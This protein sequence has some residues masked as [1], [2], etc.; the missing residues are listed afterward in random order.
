MQGPNRM[1]AMGKST[2][3]HGGRTFLR[4]FKLV[5]KGNE[6]RLALVFLCIIVSALV[7]VFVSSVIR[8][9]IDDYITP[10][11]LG[12]LTGFSTLG[13]AML[14]WAAVMLMGVISVFGYTRIMVT[15]AQ[16]ALRDIRNRM[17]EKLERLPIS[18]YDQ[19]Q[20]GSTMSLFTNDADA[21]QQM[22]SQSMVGVAS[23][24]F[25]AVMIFISMLRNSWKLTLIVVFATIIMMFVTRLIASRSGKNFVSQQANLARVNGFIEEMINGSKVVKVFCHEEE[26]EKDFDAINEELCKQ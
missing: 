3:K 12:D 22:I 10:M 25:T 16:D 11:I 19:T 1:R 6:F 2:V 20:H 5:F 7:T 8:T 14:R 26:S 9:L 17:F 13:F 4:L 21:L 23:A 24:I 15:I 18:Y